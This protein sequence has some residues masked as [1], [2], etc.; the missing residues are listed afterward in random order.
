MILYILITFLRWVLLG[1]N[2]SVES[3]K[4]TRKIE[5]TVSVA[6]QVLMQSFKT[7]RQ[8]SYSVHYFHNTIETPL[9]VG[10]G[11]SIHHTTRSKGI[12]DQLCNLQLPISYEKVLR[13]IIAL[14]NSVADKTVEN[15]GLYIPTGID[16]SK[17]VY[18]AIDNTDISSK[19][20]HGDFHGTASVVYQ[21]DQQLNHSVGLDRDQVLERG[22][23]PRPIYDVK[24]CPAPTNFN[25][26]FE[27]YFGSLDLSSILLYN[28]WD[29]T[30]S[31]MGSL[32]PTATSTPTWSAF[33]SLLTDNT[34]KTAYHSLPLLRSSPTDWSTFYTAL[35]ICQDKYIYRPRT[36][37]NHIFRY[38]TIY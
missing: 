21:S 17:Q 20:R 10:I 22:Y 1:P 29:T 34:E 24:Y 36:E 23:K 11:L 38:A 26:K 4:R 18:F 2:L 3:E 12:V 7:T 6:A 28:Q 14:S 8:S 16:P 30:W 5:N 19:S 15:N 32:D 9:N 35:C 13:F 37:Y 31:F 27:S 25:E 33:N